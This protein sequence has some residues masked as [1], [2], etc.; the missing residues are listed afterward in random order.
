MDEFG[1]IGH[2]EFDYI[3]TYRSLKVSK[4]HRHLE[5]VSELL[6]DGICKVN[7]NWGNQFKFLYES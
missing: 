5:Y 6:C 4:C 3:S 7:E 2:C 1:Y